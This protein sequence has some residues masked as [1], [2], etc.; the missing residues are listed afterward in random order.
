M[1]AGTLLKIHR[2]RSK[3]FFKNK[4]EKSVCMNEKC[5]PVKKMNLHL[6][7]VRKTEQIFKGSLMCSMLSDTCPEGHNM[8][9]VFTKL[10]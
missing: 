6:I 3:I 8:V 9:N 7:V 4:F 10:L 1:P 5:I 2:N